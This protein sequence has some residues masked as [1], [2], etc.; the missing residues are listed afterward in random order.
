MEGTSTRGLDWGEG[1]HGGVSIRL[2]LLAGDVAFN[3]F[4][5]IGGQAGPPEL[6]SDKL[7]SLKEARMS[8]SFVV[9]MA[10]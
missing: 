3:I 7:A 1:E 8:S 6:S 10:E 4:S 9:M 5:D 2:V